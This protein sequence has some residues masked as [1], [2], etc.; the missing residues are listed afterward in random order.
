[1]CRPTQ[2][3][4]SE[5]NIINSLKILYKLYD[6]TSQ[7]LKCWMSNNSKLDIF[8]LKNTPR[9]PILFGNCRKFRTEIT[10]SKCAHNVKLRAEYN[11][12]KIALRMVGIIL[13]LLKAG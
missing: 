11:Q 8:P 5:Q 7:K 1:M 10:H 12:F 9:K 2:Y 6:K 13:T 3:G 4:N